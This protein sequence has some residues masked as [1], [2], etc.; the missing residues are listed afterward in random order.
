M[1]TLDIVF[2]YFVGCPSYRRAWTDLLDAIAEGG[3][4]VTIRPVEVEDPD[5]AAQ[6]DFAGS[7]SIRLNGRD[8]EGYEGPGVLA[9]RVYRENGG[10]GWPSRELLAAGLARAAKGG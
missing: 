8:L 6:L 3:Y 7:P 2:L 1:L 10:V 4:Q 9:C 5:M